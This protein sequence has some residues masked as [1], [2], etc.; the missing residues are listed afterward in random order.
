MKHFSSDQ[1][2]QIVD[3]MYPVEYK[4]DALIIKEGDVG[5]QVY[6]LEGSPLFKCAINAGET[7]S[8]NSKMAA[9]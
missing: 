2:R 3:C 5:S 6:V 8:R 1:L 4:Q 9:S 7:A